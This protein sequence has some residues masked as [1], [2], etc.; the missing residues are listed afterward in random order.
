MFTMGWIV[1]LLGVLALQW[2]DGGF[3]FSTERT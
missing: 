3:P 1:V 2:A